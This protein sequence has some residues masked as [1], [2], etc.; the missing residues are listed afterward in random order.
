MACSCGRTARAKTP[1]TIQYDV[2]PFADTALVVYSG[3][4][5]KIIY[6]VVSG[7]RYSVS[8]DEIIEVDAADLQD[9]KNKTGLLKNGFLLVSD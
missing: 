3:T 9:F 4:D 7:S 5:E 6:G 8:Q 1:K 2:I